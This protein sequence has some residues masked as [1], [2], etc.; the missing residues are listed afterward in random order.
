MKIVNGN[1]WDYIGHTIGVPTNG[2]VRKD[3]R[4]V[5]GRGVALDALA[6]FKMIDANL[7]NHLLVNGNFIGVIYKNPK[8]LC[9]PVKPTGLLIQRVQDFQSIHRSMSHQF[10]LGDYVPGYWCKAG[11]GLIQKSLRDLNSYVEDNNE[12]VYIPALGCGNGGLSFSSDVK[13]LMDSMRLS[14]KIT[15]VMRDGDAN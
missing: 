4:G 9:I 12:N 10:K 7:G 11:L 1:I 2:F 8:I 5:M 14:D 15:L 6:R 13:P 3:G